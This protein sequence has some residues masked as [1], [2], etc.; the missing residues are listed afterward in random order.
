MSSAESANNNSMTAAPTKTQQEQWVVE[1][2]VFQIF[3]LFANL[4]RNAKST[5]YSLSL[6]LSFSFNFLLNQKN[7]F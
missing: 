6:S 4:P 7:T 3:D 1:N 2:Q 5:L